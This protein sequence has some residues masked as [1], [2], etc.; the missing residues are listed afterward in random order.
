MA[1]T[2]D[3]PKTDSVSMQR[4]KQEIAQR[5]ERVLTESK[6]KRLKDAKLAK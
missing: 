5:N 4:R 3:T 2:Q 1:T 6:K